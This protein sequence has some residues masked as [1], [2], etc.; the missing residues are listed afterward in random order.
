MWNRSLG[1]L[2]D[3]F[4][5]CFCLFDGRGFFCS[6]IYCILPPTVCK[7][8]VSVHNPP[9]IRSFFSLRIKF[10]ISIGAPIRLLRH[11]FYF[12]AHPRLV[13]KGHIVKPVKEALS[14]GPVAVNPL[15]HLPHKVTHVHVA[16]HLPL[17]FQVARHLRRGSLTF[18]FGQ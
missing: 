14:V 3:L 13:P 16:S 17:V 10:N 11:R 15:V 5:R 1:R 7:F 9:I 12:V 4:L 18:D 2:F 6:L 8:C